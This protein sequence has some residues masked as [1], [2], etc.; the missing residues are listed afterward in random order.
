MRASFRRARW[1][2]KV[3]AAGIH[4]ATVVV[5][6]AFFCYACLHRHDRDSAVGREHAR[7]NIDADA[8]Q[9]ALQSDLREFYLQTLGIRAAF[10]ILG[11]GDIRIEPP[12]FGRGWPARVAIEARYRALAKRL[13]PDVGGDP[14]EFRKVQWAIDVLRKYRPGGDG[15]R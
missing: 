7:Y 5:Q 1:R 13:H 8:S 6:D 12:R 2:A 4:S 9:T 15:D 3:F 10:R 11:F 14:E